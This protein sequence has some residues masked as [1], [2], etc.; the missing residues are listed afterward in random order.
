MRVFVQETVFAQHLL[1]CDVYVYVFAFAITHCTRLCSTFVN[2]LDSR[3][4]KF[5]VVFVCYAFDG[6]EFSS[7]CTGACGFKLR[8]GRPEVGIVARPYVRTCKPSRNPQRHHRPSAPT[9]S[10][11]AQAFSEQCFVL[12][13]DPNAGLGLGFGTSSSNIPNEG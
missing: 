12:A 11:Q 7:V 3:L 1:V 9:G 10:H 5:N 8:L 6:V 13:S 2:G 4:S